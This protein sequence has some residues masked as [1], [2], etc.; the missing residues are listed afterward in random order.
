M[1]ITD[2]AQVYFARA[3]DFE[4]V[5]ASVL[6]DFLPAKLGMDP[7]EKPLFLRVQN[8]FPDNEYLV[9]LF[10][11]GKGLRVPLSS[12]ATQSKRRKLL[13]AYSDLSPVVGI[14]YDVEDEPQDVMLVTDDNRAIVIKSSLI[15]V[16]VTRSSAGVVLMLLKGKHTVR[17]VRT[18]VGEIKGLRKIKIPATPSPIPP[19]DGDPQIQ[20]DF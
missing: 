11:N 7:G 15:P 8:R 5:K 14:L 13:K 12:Y 9:Y 19:E 2:Q 17:E 4:N 16:K 20:I 3:C 18:G 10:E 1:F 6:G